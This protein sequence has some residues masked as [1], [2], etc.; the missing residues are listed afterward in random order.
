[1][2]RLIAF[3]IEIPEWENSDLWNLI[4]ELI[5][6]KGKPSQAQ[7]E[8]CLFEEQPQIK[9]DKVIWIAPGDVPL[10]LLK[11]ADCFNWVENLANIWHNGNRVT[12]D[13]YRIRVVD[14]EPT[15][16]NPEGAFHYDY[17]PWE[18]MT[19]IKPIQK[20]ETEQI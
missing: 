7:S 9:K 10:E 11:Y 15:E 17:I 16:E 18:E 20:E 4:S 6:D 12:K 8:S 13:N 2:N 1:M 14:I 3:T 19:N 5:R